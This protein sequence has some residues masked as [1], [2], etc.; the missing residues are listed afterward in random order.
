MNLTEL[1]KELLELL[2]LEVPWDMVCGEFHEQYGS[3]GALARRLFEL[4]HAELATI[5]SRAPGESETSP[6]ALEAD[7]LMNA[8]YADLAA[9]EPRWDIVATDDG[10]ERIKVRLKAD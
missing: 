2:A 5:S 8:C 3:P 6:G 7:A 10:Y 1:D 9:Q 4:C